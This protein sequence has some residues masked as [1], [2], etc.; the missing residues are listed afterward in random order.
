MFNLSY[1]L[2]SVPLCSLKFPLLSTMKLTFQNIKYSYTTS[3][4]VEGQYLL[5][6]SIILYLT[7]AHYNISCLSVPVISTPVATPLRKYDNFDE[8]LRIFTIQVNLKKN[9]SSS[10]VILYLTPV[11]FFQRDISPWSRFHLPLPKGLSK[12]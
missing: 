10:S 8:F 11:T 3:F 6:K 9:Q 12:Y 5:K 4:H 7:K 1:P 2:V